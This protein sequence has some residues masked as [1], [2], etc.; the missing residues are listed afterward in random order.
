[1]C[2]APWPTGAVAAFTAVFRKLIMWASQAPGS[3]KKVRGCR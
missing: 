2:P 1:L 3:V